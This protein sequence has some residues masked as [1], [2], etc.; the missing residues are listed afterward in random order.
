[1]RARWQ[2]AF[3]AYYE[4]FRPD[5]VWL[6]ADT[7]VTAQAMGAAVGFP[8]DDQPMGGLGEPLVRIAR[9][10]R[11]HTSAR[12][13]AAGSVAVDDRGPCSGS[14][15]RLRGRAFVVACFDQYPFSLACALMGMQQMMTSVMEDRSL[16]AC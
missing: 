9:G 15:K 16:V 13:D 11:P 1:M 4:R 3:C 5:A 12:R 6:S 8:G 7:W 14:W 10:C 2:N